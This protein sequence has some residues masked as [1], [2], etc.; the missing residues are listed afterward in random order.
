MFNRRAIH[1]KYNNNINET[2]LEIQTPTVKLLARK[3]D[4]MFHIRAIHKTNNNN[5]IRR[6]NLKIRPQTVK[7]LASKTDIMFNDR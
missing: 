6:I 3:T 2:N 5:I 4:I 7:L 1:K